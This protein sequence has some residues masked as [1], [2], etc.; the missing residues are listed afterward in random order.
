MAA[1]HTP[2]PCEVIPSCPICGGKMETVYDRPASRVCVCVDCHTGVTV[3]ATAWEVARIKLEFQAKHPR[4][5][6]NR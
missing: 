1:D 6:P 4:S 2:E 3:P 5:E